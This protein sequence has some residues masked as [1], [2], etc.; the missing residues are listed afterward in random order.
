M[1]KI[2]K[3]CLSLQ[4]AFLY[5]HWMRTATTLTQSS[6]NKVIVSLFVLIF[7]LNF[8]NH[9]SKRPIPWIEITTLVLLP[10]DGVSLI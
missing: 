1:L 10:T 6:G 8:W 2:R 9:I 7:I 3:S 4:L 5:V